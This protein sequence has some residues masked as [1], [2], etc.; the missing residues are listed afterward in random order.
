M[1]AMLLLILIVL[2]S[3][4][5]ETRQI[6]FSVVSEPPDSLPDLD[7]EDVGFAVVDLGVGYAEP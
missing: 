4:D 7:C 3:D 1:Y 2:R 5:E 6:R